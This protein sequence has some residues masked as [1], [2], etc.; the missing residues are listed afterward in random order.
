MAEAA[1]ELKG[2]SLAFGGLKVLHDVSF[3]ARAGELLALIGPN[4]AGKTSVLN[5]ICGLYRPAAGEILFKGRAITCER[6]HD[7]ARA[8]VARTF[9]HG[10]LF[11]GM[12]VVENLLVARHARLGTA[13]L[14]EAL[15]TPGVRAAESAHRRRVEEILDFVDLEPYRHHAVDTL[16]FGLQKLVGFAR[17]LAMEPQV[18]LL[19]EPS[20][21]LNRDERE[22]LARHL[23]RIRHEL[24]IPMIWVEHD[25]QMVADLA[26]RICVLNYGRRLAE[27]APDVVLRDPQVA[28]AYLG[29]AAA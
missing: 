12:S 24:G 23:L 7:I 21:G 29:K 20:A 28:E 10:E 8:G 13:L 9:Q 5:C 22:D 14:G 27:G 11:A 2:V 3:A 19:D 4:G 16:P 15:F 25:M 6:P 17:A 1:L 26:D 18:L